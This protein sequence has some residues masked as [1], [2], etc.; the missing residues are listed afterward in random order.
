MV[1]WDNERKQI[2]N[3]VPEE[4]KAN[5][6]AGLCPVCAKTRDQFHKRMRVYC[7][8]ECKEKYWSKIFTWGELREKILR[9]D[10]ET[11]QKCG[12]SKDKWM[13]WRDAEME[14]KALQIGIELKDEIEMLRKEM[15]ERVEELYAQAMD[16]TYLAKRAGRGAMKWNE[17]IPYLNLQVD[18]IV[19][20]VNGGEMWDEKNLQTLCGECHKEKTKEDMAVK[21]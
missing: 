12:M 18:H 7:S 2:I 17:E 19:A 9:R 10:Q 5:M 8:L 14:K 6:K 3:Q 1:E 20:I 4:W 21:E 13:K 11:C 15:L 16:D